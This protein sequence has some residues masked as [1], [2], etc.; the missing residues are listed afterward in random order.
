MSPKIT[1]VRATE[2]KTNRLINR[3]YRKRH[4]FKRSQDNKKNK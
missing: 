2:N 3:R 4:K 1:K